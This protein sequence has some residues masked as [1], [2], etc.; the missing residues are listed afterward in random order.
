MSD[1]DIPETDNRFELFDSTTVGVAHGSHSRQL[2]PFKLWDLQAV[3][4]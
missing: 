2:G 3:F 1:T 4:I